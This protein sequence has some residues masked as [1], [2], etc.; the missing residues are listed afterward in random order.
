M[1][2]ETNLITSCNHLFCQ[3]CMQ[4]WYNKG[5]ISCPICRRKDLDFFSI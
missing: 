1:D 4:K 5:E 3:S 2:N